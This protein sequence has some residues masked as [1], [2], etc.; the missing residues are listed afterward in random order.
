[1]SKSLKEEINSLIQVESEVPAILPTILPNNRLTIKQLRFVENYVRMGDGTK[2]A[3]KA[4]YSPKS[5]RVSAGQLLDNPLIIEAVERVSQAV[6]LTNEPARNR[7][8][9]E[10]YEIVLNAKVDGNTMVLLK[11]LD[12]LCKVH[13]LYAPGVQLTQ[14]QSITINYIVPDGSNN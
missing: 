10:L 2:A 13:G 3:I 6:N 1:M 4:G 8:E 9:Q 5:A 7:I 14:D 11:A 12:M